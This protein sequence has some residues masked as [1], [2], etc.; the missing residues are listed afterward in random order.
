M[1]TRPLK[2]GCYQP[3]SRCMFS[4]T[5]GHLFFFFFF[6]RGTHARRALAHK[7]ALLNRR[8]RTRPPP[9]P[10][11]GPSRRACLCQQMSG[12]RCVFLCLPLHSFHLLLQRLPICLWPRFISSHSSPPL[13]PSHSPP[14]TPEDSGGSVVFQTLWHCLFQKHNPALHSQP[15]PPINLPPHFSNP[16][17]AGGRLTKVIKPCFLYCFIFK[18]AKLAGIR[19]CTSSSSL[20]L[21]P[22]PYLSGTC[23]PP[24]PPLLPAAPSHSCGEPMRH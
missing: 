14:P 16:V 18:A 8:P 22:T 4:F 20:Q 5:L 13:L 21:G 3:R 2:R 23:A 10:P 11:R 7:E 15:P 19:R 24:H 17:R 6:V 9:P 12:R 1:F